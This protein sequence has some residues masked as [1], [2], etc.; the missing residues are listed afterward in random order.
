MTK[1][2]SN[3]Q[4]NGGI[5]AHTAQKKMRVQK[6]AGKVLVSIFMDQGGIITYHILTICQ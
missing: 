4:W 3:N 2:Q 6:S 1:R 5:A